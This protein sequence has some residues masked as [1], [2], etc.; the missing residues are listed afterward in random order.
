MKQTLPGRHTARFDKDFVVF[1]IGAQVNSWW[2]LP[3]IAWFSG[4]M[5]RH[6]KALK[7]DRSLGMFGYEQF[8]RFFPFCTCLVSY[9]ESFDKLEAFAKNSKLPHLGDWREYNKR[10][11]KPTIGIWHETYKIRAG[12]FECVYGNMPKFGLGKWAAH[13]SVEES[14]DSARKRIQ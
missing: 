11:I 8:F 12:E 13:R 14:I 6:L 1:L 10:V 9:W 7:A 3:T 2:Q 5:P 4:T